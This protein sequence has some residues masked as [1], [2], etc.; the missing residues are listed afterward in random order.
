MNDEEDKE[1]LAEIISFPEDKIVEIDLDILEEYKN[2]ATD[3]ISDET[4]ET[5]DPMVRLHNEI[6]DLHVYLGPTEQDI[7]DRDKAIQK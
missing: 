6:I 7:K 1:S 4:R 2:R 5:K 3:W